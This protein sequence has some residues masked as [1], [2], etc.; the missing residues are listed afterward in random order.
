MLTL[1]ISKKMTKANARF[2]ILPASADGEDII[3]YPKR[4]GKKVLA[5]F[6]FLRNQEKKE[7][8][9][10]NLSLSDFIAP[11]ERKIDD[12]LG[13]FVVTAGLGFDEYVKLS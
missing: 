6:H 8:G 2:F 3:V 5:R 1:I 12:Y 11:I 7:E 10:P 4:K 9:K 13:G